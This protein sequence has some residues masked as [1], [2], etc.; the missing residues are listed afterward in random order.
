MFSLTN[1]FPNCNVS[2]KVYIISQPVVQSAGRRSTRMS[3]TGAK[4]S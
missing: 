1:D 4:Y 3:M 2:G